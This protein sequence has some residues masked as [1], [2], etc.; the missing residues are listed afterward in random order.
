MRQIHYRLIALFVALLVGMGPSVA[1]AQG[2]GKTVTEL[3]EEAKAQYRELLDSAQ[4]KFASGDLEGAIVD[5]EAAYEIRPSSN[6]L[7]NVGR[8]HEQMGNI[9]EAISNYERF[10]VA[11]NVDI[12]PRQ[13]AVTRLK[14]LREVQAMQ[15]EEEARKQA[16]ANPEPKPEPKPAPKAVAEPDR[17]LAWVFLGVG[18]ATLIGGGVFG[19]L[20]SMQHSKYE[21]A[22][23]LQARRDAA[24]SGETFGYVADGLLITGVVTGVLGAIFWVTASPDEPE[25][26]AIV[27]FIGSDGA[28]V[29][30]TWSFE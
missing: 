27:P 20:T 7:Y 18:A 9:D 22:T 8:I 6:I 4:K 30:M 14:T 16:A 21:D 28:G 12:K 24:S 26:M 23:T 29:G 17:T 19:V 25:E 15:R 3:T 11:P 10:I 5:F 13:D 1:F 2:S